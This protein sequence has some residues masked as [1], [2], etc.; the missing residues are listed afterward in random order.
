MF[1]QRYIERFPA[2]GEV[3]I[4]D[5]SW[6]TRA[7]VQYVMGFV[8]EAEHK[9]LLELCREIERYIVNGGIKLLKLRLE[10]GQSEQ[11]RRFWLAS[12]IHFVSGN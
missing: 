1:I 4:F 11:E 2:A 3:I 7:G 5:R 6:Y 8:S 12:M 10:M 9:R